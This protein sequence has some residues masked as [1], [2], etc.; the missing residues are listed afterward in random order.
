M[1]TAFR[2]TDSLRVVACLA[3]LLLL[4]ACVPTKL[5]NSWK[6]S[7]P[8]THK[9]EKVAVIAV[10]PDALMRQAVEVDIAEILRKKGTKAVASSKLPGMAGGIRGHIDTDKAT[11]TLLADGVDGVV[12]IFY[13]GGGRSEDYVRDDY[14]ARYVGTG[15]GYGW[16]APYT[17]SVYSIHRGEDIHD[18]TLIT[19]VESSY[20]DLE[21][22]QA[23]WRII[24]ET[25]D[26]E[27]TD[28]AAAV[29]GKIAHQMS[30][31]GLN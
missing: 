28:T 15:V 31:A 1:M 4:S 8:V 22:Q 14:Y 26:V 23:V 17:V 29:A 16:G 13:T 10:L 20:H 7:E 2:K 9:P 12:V 21:T 6:T 5:V 19:Y 3:M 30:S 27:H 11:Q 24:T 18:F 25:K